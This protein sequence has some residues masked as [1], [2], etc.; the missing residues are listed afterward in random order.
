[1]EGDLSCSDDHT[2]ESILPVHVVAQPLF[3]KAAGNVTG[4]LCF[5]RESITCFTPTEELV[6][7]VMA[8]RVSVMYMQM[9]QNIDLMAKMQ[10]KKMALE[11]QARLA[12]LNINFQKEEDEDDDDDGA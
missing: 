8:S 12:R 3:D 1:M 5:Q 10:A 9:L 6:F 7:K 11:Q 4:V 2:G